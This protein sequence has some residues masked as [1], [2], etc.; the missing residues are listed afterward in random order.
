MM[1]MSWAFPYTFMMLHFQSHLEDNSIS[2]QL[3]PYILLSACSEG[4]RNCVTLMHFH[5]GGTANL[6]PQERR[7]I[8]VRLNVTAVGT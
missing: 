4:Q 6:H 3:T 8:I 5:S 1:R 2:F 7:P